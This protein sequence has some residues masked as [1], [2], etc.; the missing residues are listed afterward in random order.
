MLAKLD[1]NEVAYYFDPVCP[2]TWKT[3]RWLVEASTNL[4]F[5]IFWRPFS[6]T[7]LN[8]GSI[9]EEYAEA[10][11]VSS[12]VLRVITQMAISERNNEVFDFYKALGEAWFENSAQVSVDT[13][14]RVLVELELGH[15]RQFLDDEALDLELSEI[16]RY[17]HG[18]AGDGTGSPV[19]ELS[20]GVGVY[21][22]ILT[23]APKGEEAASL[24]SSVRNL[25]LDSRFMELKRH[26]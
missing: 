25:V 9:P 19:L 20:N 16:H 15:Y 26:H 8:N 24:Y 23:S 18:L 6:L 17:A 11:K 2:W 1:E 14:E 3:S 10:M 22:P 7:L 13:V 12:K 4:N 21:G 5:E